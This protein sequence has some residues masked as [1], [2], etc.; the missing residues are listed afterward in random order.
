V[1]FA[2]SDDYE[3]QMSQ[4]QEEE[5]KT[6]KEDEVARARSPSCGF[7]AHFPDQ[8]AAIAQGLRLHKRAALAPF[9]FDPPPTLLFQALLWRLSHDR[10]YSHLTAI[11]THLPSA[12]VWCGTHRL[13]KLSTSPQA[14]AAG[15][16]WCGCCR[17]RA[18]RR[19]SQ[20]MWR[21]TDCR[22]R[23]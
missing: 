12:C 9:R 11:G 20:Q 22:G 1:A 10:W 21:Q 14:A 16:G 4:L 3:R 15:A 13:A 8:F 7:R 23:S 2:F 5:K 18:F 6:E 19:F 17:A